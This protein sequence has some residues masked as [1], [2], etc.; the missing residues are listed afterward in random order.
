MAPSET[1]LRLVRH[2]AGGGGR[3]ELRLV[4]HHEHRIPVIALR[5]EEAAE[6]GRRAAH[7]RLR[8]ETLEA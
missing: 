2:V 3:E 6:E 7:L 4:H 5:I 1:F 8:I